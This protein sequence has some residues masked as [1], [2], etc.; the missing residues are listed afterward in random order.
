MR[1]IFVDVDGV[2]NSNGE[3]GHRAG[4][5]GLDIACVERLKALAHRTDAQLVL[6]SSWR[7]HEDAKAQLKA[8]GLT[9]IGETPRFKYAERPEEIDAW[10]R[11][12]PKVTQYV[13]IDDDHT[14]L[15]H[16]P[17]FRT[18]WTKGLTHEICW[19]I[20]QYFAAAEPMRMRIEESA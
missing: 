8:V 6:S 3:R 9:F 10:L 11:L 13:I 2:L 5:H 18:D 12:H 7:H 14:F 4:T 19:G 17:H 15:P 20:D 16:Q 1:V